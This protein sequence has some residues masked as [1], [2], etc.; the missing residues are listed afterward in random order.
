VGATKITGEDVAVVVV[1]TGVATTSIKVVV[2]TVGVTTITMDKM[3]MH[4]HIMVVVGADMVGDHGV[5]MIQIE[6][7]PPDEA[8][9]GD[10]FPIVGVGEGGV[11]KMDRKG[12]KDERVQILNLS[13]ANPHQVLTYFILL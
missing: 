12:E 13:Y 4:R 8:V 1:T 9:E 10:I 5:V 6:T 3:A 7:I 11:F 2:A